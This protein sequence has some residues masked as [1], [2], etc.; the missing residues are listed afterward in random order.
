MDP[1]H[2]VRVARDLVRR[3]GLLEAELG[4]LRARVEESNAR[5]GHLEDRAARAEELA[6]HREAALGAA[7]VELRA[8]GNLAAARATLRSR[9]TRAVFLVHHVEAWDSL[10]DLVAEM[11]RAPDFDPV[12]VSCPRHFHGD[13]GFVGEE[14]VHRGLLAR[15][16]SHL[17]AGGTADGDVLALVRSL[18]PDLVFRQS[19][20]DADVLPELG[21]ERLGF[22]RLCLVPYETVNLVVNADP[23]GVTNSAVDS[24]LHRAAWLVAC[25]NEG[26]RGT[27]VRDG[28]RGGEQFVVVGHPKV[29]RLRGAVPRW[30]L[31][32]PTRDR[33]PRVVWSAHH[34]IGRGWA[35]FGTFPAV[36]EQALAWA[37]ARPDVDFVLMPHPA[38]TPYTATPDSPYSAVRLRDWRRRWESLPNTTVAETGDYA[39][40]LAACDVVVTDG[41][42][43]LVEPQVVGRPVVF[44]E[45]EGHRP[46][47]DAGAL[48]RAGVH[49]VRTLTEARGAAEPFLAGAP[50]PLRDRQR[51]TVTELFGTGRSVDRLLAALRARIADERGEPA[52]PVPG[53][54]PARRAGSG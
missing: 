44:L 49:G 17:R 19:Q 26:A 36:A 22:A 46:F 53:W 23:P 24:P 5:A 4:H 30:P 33:R 42:S 3:F 31:D 54:P 8:V 1:R 32:R 12:V 11:G 50:D 38:L 13:D 25:A 41:L 18:D 43:M 51:R 45:R 14:R 27:A 9:T 2:P 40:L 48:V 39:P 37:R 35:D 10:H 20:W 29:D 28:A 47:T 21:A 7:L 6:S 34:S 15:G 52:V 16:V